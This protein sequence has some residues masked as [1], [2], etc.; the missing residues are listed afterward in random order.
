MN[1][2]N[3]F[4]K[5]ISTALLLFSISA[6][7]DWKEAAKNWNKYDADKLLQEKYSQY[8]LNGSVGGSSSGS[9]TVGKINGV[10]D[11][12]SS[13]GLD[14]YLGGAIGDAKSM[15]NMVSGTMYQDLLM[16]TGLDLL[17]GADSALLGVC[18]EKSIDWSLP[19]I[20]IPDIKI[21]PCIKFKTGG[22]VDMCK[23]LPDIP[24]YKKKSALI[25]A[26]EQQNVSL[27]CNGWDDMLQIESVPIE[28]KLLNNDISKSITD[29]KKI[30]ENTNV[31][32]KI[33]RTKVDDIGDMSDFKY[34][35]KIKDENGNIVKDEFGQAKTKIV[36]PF[37]GVEDQDT[38]DKRNAHK[39]VK[40]ILEREASEGKDLDTIESS[41]K[42]TLAHLDKAN[43]AF[44]NEHEYELARNEAVDALN[45]IEKDVFD[46]G[47][48]VL[49]FRTK[50]IEY[51]ENESDVA[52]K[53]G[54]IKAEKENLII[55]YKKRVDKWLRIKESYYYEY[56]RKGIHSPTSYYIDSVTKNLE[57]GEKHIKRASLIYQV[58]KEM[59][60]D[61]QHISAL[62]VKADML[63]KEFERKLD[64][65]IVANRKFDLE[66]AM[67][68]VG[69]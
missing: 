56:E 64:I 27:F 25:L 59:N 9:S 62:R 39:Y 19:N 54:Q 47:D 66:G 18:Y 15:V 29:S 23:A 38:E 7:A 24:G 37:K 30:S 4:S 41:K 49:L 13:F 22:E 28:K 46:T 10:L 69:L 14:K 52:R 16:S 43:I 21:D 44:K 32:D 42:L 26:T 51:E 35:K 34:K 3:K 2:T 8:E 60:F 33:K 65:E 53:V 61:A 17:G 45:F 36:Q 58:D 40:K 50:V 6:N 1:T 57:D 48:E 12:A 20:K 55:Q 67:E 5:T 68:S 31:V 11:K 63:V